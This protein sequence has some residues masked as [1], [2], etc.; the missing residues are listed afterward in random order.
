[1]KYIKLFEY[2]TVNV[3]LKKEL[4]LFLNEYE[5]HKKRGDGKY[6]KESVSMARNYNV[7]EI[8][9]DEF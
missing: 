5:I 9:N 6:Y 4:N 3:E 7:P 2:K 8:F 1:M